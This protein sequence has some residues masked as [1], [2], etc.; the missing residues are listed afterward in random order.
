MTAAV[1]QD[2]EQLVAEERREVVEKEKHQQRLLETKQATKAPAKVLA[3]DAVE[4]VVVAAEQLPRPLLLPLPTQTVVAVESS[5]AEAN[6]AAASAA[7]VVVVA[8]V[9]REAVVGVATEQTT[10]SDHQ[11][12]MVQ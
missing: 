5:V 2:L 7:T 8:V 1:V 9:V 3:D 6:V 10:S 12:K 4:A 11:M